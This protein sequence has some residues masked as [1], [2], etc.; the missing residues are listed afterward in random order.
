[1]TTD[2]RGVFEPEDLA[3]LGS[4]FDQIWRVVASELGDAD[5]TRKVAARR[6][7]ANIML[8]L[9]K[10]SRLEP[11]EIKRMAIQIFQSI[12]VRNDRADPRLRHP[13]LTSNAIEGG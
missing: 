8:Q 2:R 11:D 12:E 6:R 7:L 13:T 1:M 5:H 10:L 9:A 3:I 4:A